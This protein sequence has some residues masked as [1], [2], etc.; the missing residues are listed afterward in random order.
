MGKENYGIGTNKVTEVSLKEIDLSELQDIVP[1]NNTTKEE[2][3][4]NK[5]GTYE[6]LNTF[7]SEFEEHFPLLVLLRNPYLPIGNDKSTEGC[8]S[9]PLDSVV[10]YCQLGMLSGSYTPQKITTKDDK[11]I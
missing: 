9:A 10:D 1:I 5:N 2:M 7:K 6:L 8:I 3:L 4:P 11:T